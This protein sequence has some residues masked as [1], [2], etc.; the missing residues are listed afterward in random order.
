GGEGEGLWKGGGRGEGKV[1]QREERREMMREE[2][3][4]R[5]VR[6]G[7]WEEEGEGWVSRVGEGEEGVG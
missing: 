5:V 6:G 1:E 4:M 3:K 7:V 2:V